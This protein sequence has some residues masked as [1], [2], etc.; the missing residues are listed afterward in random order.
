ML[1]QNHQLRDFHIYCCIGEQKGKY[2]AS[3]TVNSQANVIVH[4]GA[5]KS[6]QQSIAFYQYRDDS[7]Y[8]HTI[9]VNLLDSG[10]V[11]KAALSM[12]GPPLCCYNQLKHDIFSQRIK[13]IV[14]V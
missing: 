6:S 13:H 11:D 3:L 2:E 7:K 1:R 8:L 9:L 4:Y 10:P 12:V 5:E 14:L